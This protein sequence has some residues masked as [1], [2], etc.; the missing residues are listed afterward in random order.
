MQQNLKQKDIKLPWNKKLTET[1][2]TERILVTWL[3]NSIQGQDLLVLDICQCGNG[4]LTL[5]PRKLHQWQDWTPCKTEK[6]FSVK[7]WQDNRIHI[8][9]LQRRFRCGTRWNRRPHW[10]CY[11]STS[12][13]WPGV[14][15]HYFQ[16]Q[17]RR[18]CRIS[19]FDVYP[20]TIPQ[21]VHWHRRR[22]IP[23]RTI[24]S[25]NTDVTSTVYIASTPANDDSI[26]PHTRID[27]GRYEHF[28]IFGKFVT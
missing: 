27:V 4:C 28:R 14:H 5:I 13:L 1:E 17:K 7:T 25:V 16:G 10:R 12:N 26:N 19:Y 24:R 3:P 23:L 15:T 9:R 6:W 18:F 2:L 20:P 11:A 22:A 21:P 8:Y